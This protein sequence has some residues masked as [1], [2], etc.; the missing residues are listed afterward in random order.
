MS[1]S[2]ARRPAAEP[3]RRRRPSTRTSSIISPAAALERRAREAAPGRPRRVRGRHARRHLA[4]G[5]GR[6]GARARDGAALPRGVRADRRGRQHPDPLRPRRRRATAC[7]SRRCWRS[8]A[9]TTTS[10]ARARA[11]AGRPRGRVGRAARGAPH[12]L[13]ARLRRR[14]RSTRTSPS[15][16]CTSM[17]DQGQLPGVEDAADAERNMVKAMG[18]AILKTISKMGIST[19][20]SL[21]AA[22]RSSR[23]SGSRSELVDRYFTGTTSR[24]GGIGLDVLATRGARAPRARLPAHER[25][26]CRSAACT[27]GAATASTT[28]GTRTRSPRCSTRCATAAHG[29]RTRSSRS[30]VNEE[31]NA[32]GH[33]ARAARSSTRRASRSP[34]DEVEP[35]KEIVKR[36]AT[37][38]MS[39][40]SLSH[41]GA[42]DAR[43]RDEPPRRQVEHGRGRR[44]PAPLHARRERR[45][46][47][48][49][50]KQVA[51]GRFG[52]TAHYLVNADELQI[53]M[54]Q[55][56]KPGEGGQLPGHKVD[57]YIA[58]I[59]H[60]TPGVGLISPPPHHD[61]YSIEDLKQLIFDLR[62]ANPSA[63]I[64]VKLV[65]EVGVGT[66]AAGVAKANSDHV[67]IAGH[68]GGTGASPVSLDPV[69]RRAVGDR[70]RRDAADARD[71]QA[72]RPHHG[73]DRRPAED[74]PR[75]G[76]RRA[77]RR[78]GVRLLHR[79]ADHDGLHHDARLPPEHL[80][81]RH[82]HAG[83]G[84]AQALPRQ[85]R[86]RRQLL[87]L[88]RRGGA[89]AHGQ[90]GVRKFEDLVGRT[91]LL[92]LRRGDRP[93]EGARA[94][95]SATCSRR[96]RPRAEVPRRRVRAAGPGARR[97][98]RPRAD[99]GRASR[100][101]TSRRARRDRHRGAR[102]STAASAACCPARSRAATAPRACPTTRSC[103]R[104]ERL[105][106]PELRRLADARRDAR[107]SRAT[108]TTTPARASPAACSPCA[109]PRARVRARGE[110]GRRQHACSTAPPP[111]A[112]SSAASP[113]SASPCATRA[114]TAVVEGVGD[115]GCE[116]MTGG[117]VVVLGPTGRNFAA[118]MSGGAV[119]AGARALP[120]GVGGVRRAAL[121][122]TA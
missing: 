65:S 27:C 106:R 19:V 71:E 101:S 24:I 55:G 8:P 54:A 94:S 99:R 69:G 112:R 49:A 61:I 30:M 96:P 57:E 120:H 73:A 43:D 1:L 40:G 14:A 38:A 84:A 45:P 100:R 115:H 75:R 37:G 59:R 105:G 67:V 47:R 63:R 18:K 53:K 79:A 5:G 44:G 62:C 25:P 64:S 87:L 22:R 83:P 114:S 6:R 72:A 103:V 93:L 66:V 15:R 3:A 12:L 60:S 117:R 110:R 102:T 31:S 16:R 36:F 48:S 4:G 51:S 70:P 29:A 26:T 39:L 86:A 58:K 35:A 98:P 20:R 28:S 85:A 9:C 46:R 21:L 95:T 108:P 74:R 121:A 88:H 50:I 33:A 10:C 81:G 119:G 2:T 80:P 76:G 7:R 116:Y 56:A 118:G 68:D 32:Q 52:V 34:I 92:E 89:P 41:R 97:P 113:A 78:R 104:V 122:S 11:C 77:A 111:A 90:L 91:D 107:R 82:R 13:P 42:R 109:R 23:P 17:F